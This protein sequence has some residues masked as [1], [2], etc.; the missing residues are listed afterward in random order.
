MVL[1]IHVQVVL[2][3]NKLDTVEKNIEP[4]TP[5][6]QVKV[7]VARC[8]LI[9]DEHL[10]QMIVDVCMAGTRQLIS[11][12]STSKL[13]E[14]GNRALIGWCFNRQSISNSSAIYSFVLKK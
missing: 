8:N 11:D 1:K 13:K 2:G 14:T 10:L 6:G 9:S 12:E 7:D 4:N 3:W 5:A